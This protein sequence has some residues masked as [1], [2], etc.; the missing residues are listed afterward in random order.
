MRRRRG[1]GG[2]SGGGGGGGGGGGSGGG[3]GGGGGSDGG[4]GGGPRPELVG[5][6]ETASGQGGS[7]SG[8]LGVGSLVDRSSERC[9]RPAH[10]LQRA[11]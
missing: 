4:G 2:D 8:R 1:G 11:S 10:S 9:L 5:A 7:E 6:R 3:G